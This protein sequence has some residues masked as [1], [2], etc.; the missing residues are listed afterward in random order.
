VDFIVIFNLI[1]LKFYL[2]TKAETG[3]GAAIAAGNHEEKGI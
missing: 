2:C 3:V 1:M